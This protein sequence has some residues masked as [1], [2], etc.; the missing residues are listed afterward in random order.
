MTPT[1]QIAA[2]ENGSE[3]A[4]K[5]FV[6]QGKFGWKA[7]TEIDIGITLDNSTP[8]AVDRRPRRRV[9]TITTRKASQVGVIVTTTASVSLVDS[10]GCSTTV[11]GYGDSGGD[12]WCELL[13]TQPKRATCAVIESQHQQ[14][15]ANV[16]A[17]VQRARAHYERSGTPAM[18]AA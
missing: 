14:A 4:R 15:L 10:S 2:A 12:F 5:T 11:L 3:L 7:I 16:E 6:V 17:I 13:R 9:L 8:G 18:A 1:I